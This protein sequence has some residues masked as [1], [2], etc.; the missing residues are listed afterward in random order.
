VIVF[1][2]SNNG[3]L[4]R[5]SANG[6][7]PTPATTLDASRGE[8]GHRFPSFLPDGRHF[9]FAALPAKNQKFDLFIGSIDGMPAQPLIS[10]ETAAVYAEPGY[11]LY[12]R[13]DLLVAQP[14][15]ARALRVFGE[16][17][18][19]GDAPSS[20]GASYASGRAVSASTNGVLAYLGDRLPN[21]SLAWLD[22]A[23]RDAGTLAVPDGRYT[24]IAFAPDGRHASLVRL[25][26]PNNSDLWIAD[27]KR[28]DATRF[29]SLPGLSSDANWS[30]DG[31][32]IVFAN[33]QNGPRDFFV[34]LAN[35]ATQEKPFYTSK[36][37]FKDSRGWSP[38]GKY[39]IFEQL[40]PQTNR[41]LWLLPSEGDR[42]PQAYLN[43]TFNEV[44]PAISPDSKWVAYVSD[45]SG[46]SEVYV[47]AFPKPR[48]K[49]KLTDRG[50]I[51]A[52]WREDGRELAVVGADGRSILIC[53]VTPGGEFRATSPHPWISLPKGAVFG[54]P[55]P[56][57]QQVLV[58]VPVNDNNMSTLS[59]V[60][61]WVGAINKK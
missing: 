7:D 61:D 28:G 14:F 23:G 35:G 55:T 3:P 46:R 26:S 4:Q 30:T 56:D 51:A 54:Q 9:L 10:A 42:T 1:A 59:V 45:E 36:S 57:F 15:D 18:A 19:I 52:V 20:T 11:I 8:T 44:F 48:S 2:P 47:D 49:Y 38:D 24:E 32:R 34:K 13:R 29:T 53:E 27:V 43:S 17:T 25:V 22:R 21:T 6:G 33:D 58:S 5:V 60:F 12:S 50:A 39:F 31:S 37:V 40:D 41:D 16:P